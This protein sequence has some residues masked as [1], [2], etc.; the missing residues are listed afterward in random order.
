MSLTYLL[1]YYYID[2]IEGIPSLLDQSIIIDTYKDYSRNLRKQKI[3]EVD[4]NHI[5][6]KATLFLGEKVRQQNYFIE[7]RNMV[8][9]LLSGMQPVEVFQLFFPEKEKEV[10][11]FKA[12]FSDACHLIMM[13][14]EVNW[15]RM[16]C[17]NYH[18]YKHIENLENESK[19]QIDFYEVTNRIKSFLKTSS[20]HIIEKSEEDN[21]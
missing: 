3:K 19:V 9:M 1:E 6:V 14:E 7:V 5:A 13:N 8:N 17:S 15:N 16:G 21:A 2:G 4:Y 11:L 20:E 12:K 18:Y 10:E